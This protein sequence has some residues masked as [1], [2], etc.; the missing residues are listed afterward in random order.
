LI[1][2]FDDGSRVWNSIG[3]MSVKQLDDKERALF[4]KCF[5]EI[6]QEEQFD[7]NKAVWIDCYTRIELEGS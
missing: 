3:A 6:L 7:P 1:A 2:E 5:S 4:L